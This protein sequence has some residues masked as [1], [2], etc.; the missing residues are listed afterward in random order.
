MLTLQEGEYKAVD[1]DTIYTLASHNYLLKEGG[2]GCGMF[3]DNVFLMDESILDYQVLADY[4][5]EG[6][7]GRIGLEYAQTEGRITIQ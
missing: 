5:T 4:M 2:S 3:A 6:L 1:R 7:G